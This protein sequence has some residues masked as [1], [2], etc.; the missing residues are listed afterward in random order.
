VEFIGNVLD[1][2]TEYSI[3]ATDSKG[4]ILLWNE[5]AR[6]SYGYE[7][8]EVVGRSWSLLCT[9]EDIRAGL[10]QEMIRR[11][12]REGKWEGTVQRLCKD[13]S[14]FTARVV[15]TP[16]QGTDAKPGGFLLISSDI[17]EQVQLTQE[18][19][20]LEAA[21]RAKDRFLASMSH[22]L[23]T[24]LNAILGFT[25]TLL[26]ELPGPLNEDQTKQLRTVQANGKQL[27][28]LINDLLDLGR[29]ESGKLELTIERIEGHDLLEEV[30]GQLRPLADE[31]GIDL[32]VVAAVGKFEIDRRSAIA[33]PDPEQ[34][35][36]QRDQIHGRG[37]NSTG[38]GPPQRRRHPRHP[39]QRDRHGTGDT[40]RRSGAAVRRLR[41]DW[42]PDQWPLRGDW[43]RP[44]HLSDA[45]HANRRRDHL[46]E[47]AR[48]REHFHA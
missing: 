8:S 31:K 30:A 47:R 2:S 20:Q 15:T 26:M 18:N 37:R 21:G 29:I 43:A 35:D 17:T 27:L 39:V 5:G 9:D 28:S 42:T 19:Y 10:P 24:P 40:G 33:E 3:I 32:E 4:V 16:R 1:S 41:A 48:Q 22:E 6:R 34:P 12:L 45:G 13:G 46:R 38:S 11:T 25:G 7:L 23:R 36:E 44:L 14:D